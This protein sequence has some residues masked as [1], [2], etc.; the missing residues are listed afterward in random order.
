MMK[1]FRGLVCAR[2]A[3]RGP[4][5]PR[6]ALDFAVGDSPGLIPVWG[7]VARRGLHCVREDVD[8]SGARSEAKR[9]EPASCA[10]E[11]AAELE[12]SSQTC[13]GDSYGCGG[14]LGLCIGWSGARHKRC[15]AGPVATM[16]QF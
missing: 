8:T 2:T 10:I 14:E 7:R 5:T 12:S 9:W 13:S 6:A 3:I 16:R 4:S 1:A 15:N 11:L